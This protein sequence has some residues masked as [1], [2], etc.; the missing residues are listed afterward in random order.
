MKL[1]SCEDLAAAEREAAEFIAARLA[2]AVRERGLATLAISGGTTPWGMFE[3]L[4]ARALSWNA[5]HVLQVDERIV[6]LDQAARNWRRF[7]ANGLA[8]RVP[9]AN[10]HAMPVEIED[11][12]L[13]ASRYA[14]TLIGRAGDPPEL[15]VVHLGIG[16][17]GHTASLFAGDPLLEEKQRWVGVS[18]PYLKHRR[19]SLTLPAIDQARCI[20]WFAVGSGRRD[21]VRRLLDGDVAIPAGRVN[22]DRAVCFTDQAAPPA[23]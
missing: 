8:Q 13:A 17:D 3:C 14:N 10:R 1:V 15:D 6:P 11:S 21:A 12:K 2:Q 4:A 20:V 18:R 5:I 19:L 23:T 7:L 9:E 16:E 22:R